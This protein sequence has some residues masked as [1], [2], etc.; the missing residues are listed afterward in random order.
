MVLLGANDAAIE[1]SEQHVPLADFRSNLEK[2]ITHERIVAHKPT[3]LLVTP[4]PVDQIG[5]T[6]HDVVRCKRDK[7]QRHAARSAQYSQAV[8]DVAAKHKGDSKI[9]LIDLYKSIMDMAKAKS[10]DVKGAEG[11]VL[12]DPEYN[13]KDSGFLKKLLPD[14]L[15]MAGLGYKNLM[16]LML[17][18]LSVHLKDDVESELVCPDW[19]VAPPKARI[20]PGQRGDGKK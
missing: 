19:T 10:K 9:E 7:V 20:V 6:Y 13:A 15:H 1:E 8:R 2:I 18:S 4:P 14:G 3:I 12:G 17:P 5:R 11:F 16:G